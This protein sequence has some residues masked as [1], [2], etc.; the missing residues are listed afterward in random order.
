MGFSPG[1]QEHDKIQIA[2]MIGMGMSPSLAGIGGAV[3]G[4]VAK[5]V[6]DKVPVSD[7]VKGVA[8]GALGGVAPILVPPMMMM[9]R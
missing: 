6:L 5:K 3:A 4:K 9:G 2:R 1:I 7:A 8:T